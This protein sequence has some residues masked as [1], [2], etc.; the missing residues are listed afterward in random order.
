VAIADLNADGRPDLVAAGDGL[1]WIFFGYGNGTFGPKTAIT[2]EGGANQVVVADLN[3][4]G[5]LDLVA[6]AFWPTDGISVLL[7]N[8]D[9][10]FGAAARV[11]TGIGSTLVSISDLNGDG[12]PDLVVRESSD[13]VLVLLGNGDGTFTACSDPNK[14]IAH[15]VATADLNGDGRP[16]LVALDYRNGDSVSVLLG[17][18]DGTFGAKT[19]FGVGVHP[20]S[21]AIA[22]LNADG[23][24]DLVVTNAGPYDYRAGY[25]TGP[26]TISVLLGKGDGT[27]D[28]KS[29]FETA[30]YG[31]YGVYPDYPAIADLN[32]D[33]RPDVVVADLGDH[34]PGTGIGNMVSVLLGNGD[35]TFGTHTDYPTPEGIYAVALANL[36]GEPP[37]DMVVAASGYVVVLLN[38]GKT[39][40]VVPQ[41]KAF[42][43]STPSPNPSAGTIEIRLILP[44]ECP[45]EIEL[46]DVIGRRIWS[47][48]SRVNLSAGPHTV[49]WNGRDGL[50]TAAHSGVYFLKVR[51]GRDQGVR[52]LVLER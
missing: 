21:V 24:P 11:L 3:A 28:A 36:Y 33:G 8:G 23:R 29:D 30:A 4:D 42:E 2:V 26:S 31:G 37:P 16:D 46:L 43:L 48:G 49:T 35:G 38:R 44:S 25:Y 5:K 13:S 32:G 7:G 51:A 20:T 52:R 39:A 12:R 45:V 27:F 17:A 34:G 9:G 10:T 19:D 6:T 22:D 41:P 40:G 1:A 47:W 50:G 18:G 14:P 15:A